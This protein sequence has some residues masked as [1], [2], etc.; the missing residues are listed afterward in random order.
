MLDE[1]AIS[2]YTS[3]GQPTNKHSRTMNSQDQARSVARHTL[4]YFATQFLTKEMPRLA[5]N[6]E[7]K[8]PRR[9][10]RRRLEEVILSP[11]KNFRSITYWLTLMLL[12]LSLAEAVRRSATLNELGRFQ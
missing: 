4:K 6:A 5:P 2:N 7:T 9:G 10:Q 3:W 12:Q 11:A 1:P 8:L